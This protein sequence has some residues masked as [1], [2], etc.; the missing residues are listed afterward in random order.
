MIILIWKG[1]K[2]GKVRMDILAYEAVQTDDDTK[3]TVFQKINIG[4]FFKCDIQWLPKK[5]NIEGY[6]L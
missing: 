4:C 6:V 2:C 3:F 5:K 1:E